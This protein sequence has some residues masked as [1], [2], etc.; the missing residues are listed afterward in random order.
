MTMTLATAAQVSDTLAQINSLQAVIDNIQGVL[1][2]PDPISISSI[3]FFDIIAGIT[4]DAGVVGPTEA[5]AVLQTLLQTMSANM[6]VLMA[7]LAAYP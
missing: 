4:F 6:T 3:S 1:L 7:T 2:S 5:K